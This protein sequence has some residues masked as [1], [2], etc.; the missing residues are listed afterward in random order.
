M[1]EDPIW[2]ITSPPPQE[3]VIAS[4][5]SRVFTLRG[6]GTIDLAEGVTVD[7]ASRAFYETVSK[8]FGEERRRV[9][10]NLPARFPEVAFDDW[11]LEH[12]LPRNNQSLWRWLREEASI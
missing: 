7:E 5:G 6:D 10:A 8:M 1:A 11:C 12:K 4:G 9:L 2:L 3:F